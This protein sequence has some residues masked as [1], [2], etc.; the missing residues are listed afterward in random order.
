MLFVAGDSHSHAL[1]AGMALLDP[2]TREILN[3]HFGPIKIRAVMTGFRA[4]EPFF[5]L[6]EGVYPCLILSPRT[7]PR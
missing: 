1:R 5:Q 4:Y 7:S 3:S 6:S 2:A